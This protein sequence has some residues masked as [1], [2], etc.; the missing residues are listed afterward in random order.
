MTT[1]FRTVPD[2]IRLANPEQP[3]PFPASVLW[4]CDAMPVRIR[5]TSLSSQ[6]PFL[7]L[8]AA[9]TS[10]PGQKQETIVQVALPQATCFG[11]LGEQSHTTDLIT[12][13]TLPLWSSRYTSPRSETL[14]SILSSGRLGKG[15]RPAKPW[16]CSELRVVESAHEGTLELGFQRVD[17]KNSKERRLKMQRPRKTS[18]SSKVVK[19]SVA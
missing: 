1:Y 11:L 7:M 10:Q 8:K 6:V 18:L 15:I 2:I 5:C 12:R 4:A 17:P 19:P 13:T 16:L 3:P 14:E 9:T